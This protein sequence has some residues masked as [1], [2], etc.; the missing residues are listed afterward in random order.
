MT[1]RPSVG[2]RLSKLSFRRI[3]LFFE[4]GVWLAVAWALKRGIK[5]ARLAKLLGKPVAKPDSPELDPIL[6]K[7]LLWVFGVWS[8]RWPWSAVCL[9]E[10][11]ALRF[12]LMRRGARCASYLGVRS[13]GGAFQAH[14]WTTCGKQVLPRKQDV[15]LYRVISIFEP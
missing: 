8:Y 2:G 3:V 10:V 5:F 6:Y 12:L 4:T 9:T 15:E 7:D 1:V 11:I 13:E 14:A